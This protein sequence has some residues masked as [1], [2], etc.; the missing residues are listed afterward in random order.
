M[1]EPKNHHFVPRLLLE[2]W[3]DK[4]GKILAWQRK[5]GISRCDS[6]R[7]ENVA[8]VRHLYSRQ[9]TSPAERS[10]IESQFFSRIVEAPAA[11]AITRLIEGDGRIGPA[12]RVAITVFI[13]S[14]RVRVPEVIERIRREGRVL[15]KHSL[16]VPDPD[17]DRLNSDTSA[18]S[19]FE[20]AELHHPESL[21]NFGIDIVPE[22]ILHR[23][24]LNKVHK[25]TWLLLRAD[26]APF[27]V[28][29][30][31]R[32]LVAVRGIDHPEHVQA[33]PLGP[34]HILFASPSNA[35]LKRIEMRAPRDV[36][37]NFNRSVVAQ[38]DRFAFGRAERRFFDRYLPR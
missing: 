10:L 14:Q 2:R 21:N 15:A 34:R 31:D 16:S 3:A 11:A 6:I 27:E 4:C 33:I 26:N 23:P 20:W 24:T 25:M 28:L 32:P 8:K 17:F 18:N 5:N 12:E 19:L 36:I 7:A 29:L 38:A 37:S 22:L 9:A 35:I 1:T 13:I 30:S